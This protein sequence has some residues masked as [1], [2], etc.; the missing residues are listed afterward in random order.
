MKNLKS[1]VLMSLLIAVVMTTPGCSDTQTCNLC[2]P[3]GRSGLTVAVVGPDDVEHEYTTGADGCA[4]F[5]AADC[6]KFQV[7]GV[8]AP[9]SPPVN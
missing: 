9:E 3:Q 2:D 5:Q 6:S 4:S 1:F 8:I 7:V